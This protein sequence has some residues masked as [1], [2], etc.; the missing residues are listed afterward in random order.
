MFGGAETPC[1][2]EGEGLS[3]LLIVD[4]EPLV[5]VADVDPFA[6]S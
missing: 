1:R 5:E 2:V 4:G 3:A 6:A